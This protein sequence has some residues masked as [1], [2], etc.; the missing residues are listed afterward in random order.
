MK[1]VYAPHFEEDSRNQGCT[2]ANIN[3]AK[4]LVELFAQNDDRIDADEVEVTKHPKY[5]SWY[6]LKLRGQ[7]IRIVVELYI[8]AD[9]ERVVL[10]HA[11]LPRYSE[12]Y[13]DVKALWKQRRT[14]LDD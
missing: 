8:D 1:I 10:A 2:T 6:R 3:A 13:E 14:R 5:R 7:Q 11:V 4:R 9:G 12:T